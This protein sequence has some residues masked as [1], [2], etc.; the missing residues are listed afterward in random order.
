MSGDAV[1]DRPGDHLADHARDHPIVE[2]VEVVTV[3]PNP[4]VD[5][6]VTVPGFAAGSVNRVAGQRSTA[7]GKGVN[8]A[9]ALAGSGH[10][11]AAT[12]FLGR[13]NTAPFDALFARTGIADHFVR[14]A[15]DTRVGIKIVDPATRQ[16]TDVNFPGEPRSADDVARLVDEVSRLAGESAPWFVLAGSLPPGVEPTLYRDLVWKL[17]SAGSAVVLDTSGEALRLALGAA[18]A[19]VKPNVHELEAL[20]GSTLPSADAI[21]AAVRPILAGGVEL[22]VVSMGA[23]GALF[24][25]RGDAI[26]ATPPAVAVHSTVGA[27]DAMVAGI[28]ASRLAGLTLSETAR[29]ATAFSVDAITRDEGS[30]PARDGIAALRDRVTVGEVARLRH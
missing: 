14:V 21:I 29:L 24:I 30:A 17:K 23:D 6:T 20:V 26:L 28:V 3:T 1:D 25:R 13:G 19:V 12:G 5:W 8:V 4:A 7:G 16:T 18:P 27:G 22:V 11:V 10:R 9:A 15:G 2:P